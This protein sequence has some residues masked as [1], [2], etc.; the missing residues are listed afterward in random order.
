MVVAEVE[1]E[2][3]WP[4]VLRTYC[5]VVQPEEEHPLSAEVE[6]AAMVSHSFCDSLTR[7]LTTTTKA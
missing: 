6:T 4:S 2:V 5:T 3:C 1:A 7:N